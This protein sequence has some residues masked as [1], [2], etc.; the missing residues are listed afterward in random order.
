MESRDGRLI[1]RELFSVRREDVNSH[2]KRW[3]KGRWYRKANAKEAIRARGVSVTS[4]KG[5]RIGLC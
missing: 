5:M 1:H 4:R 2:G 3:P